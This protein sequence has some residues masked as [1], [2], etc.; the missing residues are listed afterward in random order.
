M[1]TVTSGWWRKS[2][3]ACVCF[4]VCLS[5]TAKDSTLVV[6]TSIDM[7]LPAIAARIAVADQVAL[8]KWDHQWP[9]FDQER[10]TAVIAEVRRLAPNYGLDGTD[11]ASFFQAQIEANKW[12]QYQDLNRWQLRGSA[13][14]TNRP[15][16]AQLRIHLDALQSM[17]LQ[18]LS[19]ASQ[20]RSRPTCRAATAHAVAHYAQRTHLDGLHHRA[21]IRAM[22]DFCHS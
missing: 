16:L 6:H 18:H 17:I 11:V 8:T 2:I 7:L 21:L 14:M 20:W 15:D 9:V 1:A 22:G 10:E 3:S 13:P 5:A 12:V 19:A 4:I